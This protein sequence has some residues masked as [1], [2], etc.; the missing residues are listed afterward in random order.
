[1]S[2]RTKRLGEVLKRDLGQIIQREYQ[3]EG[4]FITVT[5]VMMTPDLSIAKVYLS[6]FAPG[7]DEQVIYQTLDEHVPQIRHKLAAKIKNQVRKIP[8]L[9]FYVDDTAEYVNKIETLFKKID[10]EP[11][12][13]KDEEE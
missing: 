13:P 7:R 8:E 3:P 2:I 10:D 11:T 5:K 1:M 9:H 6:V 12:A 4:V